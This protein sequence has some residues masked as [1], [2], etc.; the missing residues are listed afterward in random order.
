MS[1]FINYQ[2][3][4]K[5]PSRNVHIL[6]DDTGNFFLGL[7]LKVKNTKNEYV[8]FLIDLVYFQNELG[9]NTSSIFNLKSKLFTLQFQ[10]VC[11]IVV[12]VNIL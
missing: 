7:F 8:E 12:A 2:H 3:I 6:C 11:I 1:N 4:K 10:I 9:I 5:Y